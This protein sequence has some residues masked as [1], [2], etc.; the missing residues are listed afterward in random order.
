MFSSYRINPKGA[1][2]HHDHKCEERPVSPTLCKSVNGHSS[3][4]RIFRFKVKELDS[5]SECDTEGESGI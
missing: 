1:K 5:K 3:L 2:A 4:T